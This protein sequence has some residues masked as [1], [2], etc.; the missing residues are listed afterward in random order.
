MMY[1]VTVT[2]ENYQKYVRNLTKI[3]RAFRKNCFKTH[4]FSESDRILAMVI[5]HDNDRKLISE[6]KWSSSRTATPE[7]K[8]YVLPSP[9]AKA[10]ITGVESGGKKGLPVMDVELDTF[11]DTWKSKTYRL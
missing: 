9:Q 2:T 1:H 7:G 4:F 3:K 10:V 6:G 8:T 5:T 11:V